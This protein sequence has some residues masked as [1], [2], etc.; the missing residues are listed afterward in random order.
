LTYNSNSMKLLSPL[1]AF[2]ALASTANAAIY[3]DTRTYYSNTIDVGSSFVNIFNVA[4]FNIP[5]ATLTGVTVKVVQSTMVGSITITNTG[6]VAAAI[7]AFDSQFTARQ[8]TAGLGYAQTTVDINNV[9][10]SPAWQSVTS[11]Q[12]SA[13]QTLNIASGQSFVVADQNIASGFWGAYTGSGN[14]TFSARDIQ[15]ITV[16]GDSF[17][18]NAS[19]AKATTQFAVVYSFSIPEPSTALLGGLASILL[20]RRRR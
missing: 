1:L 3:Y 12:P 19:N 13:S 14:M 18:Q 6:G 17:T 16:T 8:I 4:K 2:S 20:F 15:T 7:E 10:T 11:L 9:V 5:Q